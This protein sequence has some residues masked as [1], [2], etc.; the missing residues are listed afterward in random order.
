M[1]VHLLA[2]VLLEGSVGLAVLLLRTFCAFV[3]MLAMLLLHVHFI[4][5]SLEA[6]VYSA[7]FYSCNLY[8]SK[9]LK[10]VKCMCFIHCI[11]L[12][13]SLSELLLGVLNTRYVALLL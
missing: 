13:V 12:Y 4:F 3:Y 5:L 11:C 10:A 8:I 7:Y 1:S 2:F 9:S 6:V